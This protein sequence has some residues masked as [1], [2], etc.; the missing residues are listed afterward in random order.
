MPY[1]IKPIPLFESTLFMGN[2]HDVD[3]K[4]LTDIIYQLEEDGFCISG[5]GL[6]AVQ[7][8]GNL[9]MIDH[10]VIHRL[11]NAFLEFTRVADGTNGSIAALT[12]WANIG[13]Q[14]DE[15]VDTWHNHLPWH[16][17]CVY[18]PQ[19]PKFATREEG[20]IRFADPREYLG[21]F[22]GV[23]FIPMQGR[24]ILFPSWMRHTVVPFRSGECDR[25]SISCN[26]LIGPPPNSMHSLPPHRLKKQP[27]GQLQEPEFDPTAPAS[28]P[29]GR[30]QQ[31]V[32]LTKV[33]KPLPN[34]T[35]P[36]TT[37]SST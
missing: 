36:Q 24:M 30:R 20:S 8:A 10:P 22:P 19:V 21:R 18:Y 7:T 16:W 14:G 2:L 37:P 23:S 35:S 26:A 1:D 29:Y 15:S 27:K 9:L 12:G 6:G 33:P 3:N 11:R 5:P 17:S 13:R 4:V 25:V 32:I 31:R 28:Y 34:L